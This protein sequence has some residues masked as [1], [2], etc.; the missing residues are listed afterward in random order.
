MPVLSF[1]NAQRTRPLNL[2]L[3]RRAT[4]HLLEQ[5][6]GIA[7]YELGFRFVDPEEMA[8][9]NEKFLQHS[10]STDVITFDYGSGAADARLHGEALVSIADA[11]RQAREFRT[12]WQSEV[13][14]YII[15][16][17]LHLRGHDD[18]TGAARKLMKR[19]EN[20]LLQCIASKFDLRQ[21]GRKS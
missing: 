13:I 6:L 16:G 8:R 2:P 14:R 11:V 15:H 21:L 7:Q 4:R 18:R 12:T 10:G 19:E 20:R 17:V 3:L 9:A 1:R 5:E